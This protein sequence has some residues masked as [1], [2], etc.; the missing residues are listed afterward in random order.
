VPQRRRRVF[1]LGLHAGIDPSARG[2]AEVLSVGSRCGWHPA[3]GHQTR[4]GVAVGTGGSIGIA[5]NLTRRYGKGIN[6]TLDDG[7]IIYGPSPDPDGMR[8]PDGLAGRLDDR[9]GVAATLPLGLDSHRY[10]CCGNGVV[11]GVAEW[12][13][14]RLDGWLTAHGH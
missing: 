13:G 3:T 6:T 10:R 14:H 2:A 7:A 5:G 12:I 4:S 1:I 11:S 9:G 8:A